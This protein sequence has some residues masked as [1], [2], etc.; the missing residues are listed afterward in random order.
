MVADCL[1]RARR[2]PMVLGHAE[3]FGTCHNVQL[4][5]HR[6]TRR[7]RLQEKKKI[8][9]VGKVFNPFSNDVVRQ[10]ACI[11]GLLLLLFAVRT[12]FDE[13]TVLVHDYAVVF[14]WI[15]LCVEAFGWNSYFAEVESGL[16]KTAAAKF[17]MY[18]RQIGFPLVQVPKYLVFGIM[19]CKQNQHKYIFL[20]RANSFLKGWEHLLQ[21]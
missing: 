3:F 5:S 12:I 17:Q 7:Q 10:Y 9:V 1:S 14:V 13:G 18:D 6:Y 8:F 15:V 16:N 19:T 4:L 2:G 21:M 11:I 20:L